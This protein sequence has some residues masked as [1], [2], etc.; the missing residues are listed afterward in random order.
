M[1]IVA[2]KKTSQRTDKT[3]ILNKIAVA[4]KDFGIQQHYLELLLAEN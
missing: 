3:T 4:K 1:L 2:Q